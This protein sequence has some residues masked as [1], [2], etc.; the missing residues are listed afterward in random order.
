MATTLPAPKN[1]G[2]S[3]AAETAELAAWLRLT[4]T[5][6]V[7]AA[8]ARKLLAAF[9]SPEAVFAAAPAA[10]EALLGPRLAPALASAP[11]HLERVLA[12]TLGW[13]AVAPDRH[14]LL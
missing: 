10:R 4:T 11:V 3:A 8:T 12:Q 6:G 7:G 14:L 1:P 13:L 2:S 9:G 5:A